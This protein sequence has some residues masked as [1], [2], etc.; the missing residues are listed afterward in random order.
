[1]KNMNNTEKSFKELY[2]IIIKLRSPDGCAWDREQ[3]PQSIRGN[4]IEEAYE[5]VDAVNEG[6]SEHIKEEIGDVYLLATLF[7]VMYE[8]KGCF[9]TGDALKTISEKLVRRHPHVFAS[10]DERGDARTPD[11]IIHQWNIIKEQV[12]GRGKKDSVMDSVSKGLPPLERAYKI[13][14]TAVKLGFDWPDHRGPWEKLHEEVAEAEK[15]IDST[16][17]SRLEDEIGDILF[18]AI[19]VARAHKID[20][21]IALNQANEKFSSRFRHVEK[22]MREN[23]VREDSWT[24]EDMDVFWNEAKSQ[25]L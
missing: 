2:D 11:A 5:L 25:G 21:A 4:L 13:Q 7:A 17:R 6:D 3:T 14:K 23:G 20:P 1:M 18:A 15:E 8:E 24:Q 9:T 22:R 19:N 10:G 16:D 12:E